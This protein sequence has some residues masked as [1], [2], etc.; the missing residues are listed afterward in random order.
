[1]SS[2]KYPEGID[3][4]WLGRDKVGHVAAFITA[5]LGPVPRWIEFD[6]DSLTKVELQISNLPSISDV[7]LHISIPRP[8]GYTSLAEKGLYVFDWCD[9]HRAIKDHRNCYEKVA[10]PKP[11]ILFSQ[12]GDALGA[13]VGATNFPE[14]NFAEISGVDVTSFFADDCIVFHPDHIR[15]ATTMKPDK[16]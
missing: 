11:P 7:R 16:F 5:G 10:D 13:I 9:I 8:E 12:L 2:I 3:A 6:D 1:M 14:I 15:L 4:V